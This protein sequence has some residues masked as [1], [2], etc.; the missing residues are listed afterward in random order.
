MDVVGLDASVHTTESEIP[1][2]NFVAIARADEIVTAVRL[3]KTAS[4]SLAQ[5]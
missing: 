1:A 2:D 4:G 3:P 5:P